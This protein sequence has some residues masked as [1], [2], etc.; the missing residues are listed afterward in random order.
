MSAKY[1][2]I[3]QPH[4]N[5]FYFDW[6]G[7]IH[8]RDLL[9]FLIRRDF[10]ARYQQTVLGPAWFIIS[11]LIT[12]V[13]FTIVFG[14][15]AR[16]PTDNIPPLVFYLCGLS[17]WNFFVT[18]LSSAS[19]TL[20]GNAGLFGKVYFPR[21]IPSFAAIISNLFTLALQ[22][23]TFLAFFFYFKFF[24]QAGALIR[25]NAYLLMLPILVIHAALFSLGV[26]LWFSAITAKYR[27][28]QFVMGLIFQLWMYATPIIYPLSLVSG[29]MRL[30]ILLN[31]MSSI[32]EMFKYAFFGVGHP[33]LRSYALSVVITIVALLSG[34]LVFNRA[35]RTFIDT[36]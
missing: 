33:D 29:K 3:I 9:L 27:D 8:H 23:T 34:V 12:T 4:R 10:I 6:R 21:L 28:L 16:I 22:M 35:E 32:V 11:P 15:I 30:I 7:L 13:M 26:G 1:E 25:P 5:W 31:P 20:L 18:C 2:V 17:I 36:V 24:T 19:T 14:N